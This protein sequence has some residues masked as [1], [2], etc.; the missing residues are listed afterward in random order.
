MF[1]APFVEQSGYAS[2]AQPS[3]TRCAFPLRIEGV[4]ADVARLPRGVLWPIYLCW[5][6][7][8]DFVVGATFLAV[9]H[10]CLRCLRSLDN[11][12]CPGAVVEFFTRVCSS[13]PCAGGAG[14]GGAQLLLRFLWFRRRRLALRALPWFTC[15]ANSLSCGTLAG[16]FCVRQFFLLCMFLLRLR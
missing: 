15:L 14:W 11:R 10:A 6:L 12:R 13:C 16:F 5:A 8:Y 9:I 2:A 3:T 7:C 1:T 4:V